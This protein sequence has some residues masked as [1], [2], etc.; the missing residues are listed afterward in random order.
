MGTRALSRRRPPFPPHVSARAGWATRTSFPRGPAPGH[1]WGGG[2]WS[3][4]RL[5][6]TH[7]RETQPERPPRRDLRRWGIHGPARRNPGGIL[8]LLILLLPPRA[9]T[10]L[11]AGP[12]PPRPAWGGRGRRGHTHTKPRR[13][14][15]PFPRAAEPVGPRL[16]STQRC[17]M[18]V[19]MEA[20]R[21]PTASAP[22]TSSP[23]KSTF[24]Q[25]RWIRQPRAK[26]S[27]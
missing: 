18:S 21:S 20:T 10:C 24:P 17:S 15:R 13:G 4:S 22:N 3:P 14:A 19:S 11:R 25:C 16:P 23:T 8:N 27:A 6:T 9:V 2:G 26:S 12:A 5:S 1:A 7:P